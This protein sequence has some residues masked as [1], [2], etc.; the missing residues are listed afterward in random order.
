[1][2]TDSEGIQQMT[3]R[4]TN[5]AKMIEAHSAGRA[6]WRM[7]RPH[8]ATAE[9][10]ASMART[11]GWTGEL[12]TA[13]LAGFFGE[14]QRYIKTYCAGLEEPGGCG[15]ARLAVIWTKRSSN[16]KTG[17]MPVSTI[18]SD[19]CPEDCPLRIDPV[20]GKDGPCYAKQGRLGFLWRMLD[21]MGPLATWMS[22]VAR[23]HSTDWRGYCASVASLDA[24]TLW[25]HAQAGDLPHKRGTID[26]TLVP[27]LVKANRG[28]RGFGYTHHNV[29]QNK[30]NRELVAWANAQGFT[31]NL[32]ANTL[33]HAD[34]L[35]ELDVAPV[36]VV[37]P[38]NVSGPERIA[39]PAGR[40][41]VVCPATYREDVS[42]ATCKLCAVRERGVIVGFPAHGA[43]AKKAGAIAGA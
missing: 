22:G 28:K 8:E 26:Q 34:L 21:R 27:R 30:A 32:S 38:R 40:R 9:N 43:G 18:S 6:Y 37:L 16:K 17:P 2:T 4:I 35:S 20:T 24:G 3:N 1:M 15:A 14:K 39:T 12:E 19:T 5:E 13:W 36:V 42:C 10:L 31:I 7:N 11:L 29:L 25:R 41:V 33:R 23:V